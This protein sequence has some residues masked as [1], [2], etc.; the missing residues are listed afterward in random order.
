L[1]TQKRVDGA[2]APDA[3]SQDQ[4]DLGQA[5][6]RC[7]LGWIFEEMHARSVS[8]AK[9]NEGVLRGKNEQSAVVIA[10][11]TPT[12]P[13]ASQ[14]G[15]CLVS[16]VTYYICIIAWFLWLVNGSMQSRLQKPERMSTTGDRV[17]VVR[18]L[19]PYA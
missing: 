10:L 1:R 16:V 14:S 8:G 4:G 13:S 6:V 3:R 5:L 17:T 19:A 2:N 12:T 9:L 11:A 18:V 15:R 7:H